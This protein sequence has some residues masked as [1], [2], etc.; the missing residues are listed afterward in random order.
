ME[1]NSQMAG[2]A[3]LMN[4]GRI[5]Q[6]GTPRELYERPANA[7][8][9]SFVGP[10]NR[11]GD[12]FIRPHDLE[13]SSAERLDAGGDGRAARPP[14]L[15]GASR[16]CPRRRHAAL[17]AGDA[18][19]SGGARARGDQIVYVRAVRQTTFSQSGAAPA[20]RGS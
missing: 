6:V 8:V 13:L 7:F 4:G 11:V 16:A 3:P 15:R 10:V 18:R 1:S 20:G 17:S 2:E 9:M 19:G 14:R 12:V 5:E